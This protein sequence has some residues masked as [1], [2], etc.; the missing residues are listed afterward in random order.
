MTSLLT[1]ILGQKET[2]TGGPLSTHGSLKER[3]N[4]HC[5]IADAEFV[6]F[7]TELTGLDFKRDSIIS[8]GA[9]RLQGGR[10]LPGQSFYR[11]VRPDS[12]LKSQGVVV[13]E[14]THTDLEKAEAA[15][16][17][18]EDFVEFIGDSILIGH[19]VFI[20]VNFVTRTMKRLFGV[21]LQSPAVDT[22][23]LHDWLYENDSRFARHHGGMTLKNDLFSLAEKY[24]IEVEK[25]HNAMYDAYI[26]AQLF[27][28]FLPFLPD[29]GVRTLK[30]LLSVSKS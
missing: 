3:L 22:S 27:Q 18:L 28:R 17:V 2:V 23:A 1:R 25:A 14:L 12:E 9:V 24:G 15:A 21:G 26:T 16:V 6:S 30:D 11:L 20:D 19:F 8:I 13:H 5:S 7:D 29:C 4:L 10:I